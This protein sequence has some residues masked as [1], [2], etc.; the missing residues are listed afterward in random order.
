VDAIEFLC[1]L[2]LFILHFHKRRNP[3]YQHRSAGSSQN[4]YTT[5]RLTALVCYY[6]YI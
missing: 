6:T 1:V 3:F 5:A 4:M 2:I